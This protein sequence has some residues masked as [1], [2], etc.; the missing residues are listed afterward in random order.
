MKKIFN[1]KNKKV[2]LCGSSGILGSYYSKILNQQGADLCLLDLKTTKFINLAKKLK[3]KHLFIDCENE[4]SIRESVQKAAKKM[5]YFDCV[6]YNSAIT[7][8]YLLKSKNNNNIF[9]NLTTKTWD[10]ILNINLKGAFIFNQ[11]CIKYFSKKGG[12]IINISSIYG[13]ISPDHR[14]YN[15]EN[16]KP[17]VSYSVSK[18]GII[19]LSKWLS[20]YL[21]NKNIRVNCISPGGVKNQQSKSFINKYSN[22]IPLGRMANKEDM[23]GLLIY[24]ISDESKYVTGQ[25]LLI[26]GGLSSW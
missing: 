14:I 24:L 3:T 16:F 20:T 21:S 17:N 22:R 23:I 13:S 7:S 12:S 10:K 25:D 26:D 15:N 18:S 11:E 19:M 8:E 2:L 9:E 6:I 1:I 5:K 4:N